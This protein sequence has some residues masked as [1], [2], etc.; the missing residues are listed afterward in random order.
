MSVKVGQGHRAGDRQI[1]SIFLQKRAGLGLISAVTNKGELR[2][3]VLGGAIKAADLIRFLGRL[4]RDVG[5]KVF[6]ILDRLPVHRSAKAQAWLAGREAEIEV[7]HLPPYSPE[8]NPDEGLNAGP[9]QAVTRAAPARSKPQ[10]KRAVVGHMRR[11]SKSPDRVH[12]L[13]GHQT[14]RYAA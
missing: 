14:F 5:H 13:F 1:K 12:S 6:L 7:F 8:L 3:M 2:W 4:V 9:R 10:L 11:L